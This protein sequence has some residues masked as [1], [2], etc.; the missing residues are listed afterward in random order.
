MNLDEQRLREIKEY[1]AFYNARLKEDNTELGT[2][3]INSKIEELETEE[4]EI[5]KRCKVEI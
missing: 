1:K 4:K 5:L 2:M 3:L